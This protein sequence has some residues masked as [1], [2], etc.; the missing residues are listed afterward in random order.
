M[1]IRFI[2]KIKKIRFSDQFHFECRSQKNSCSKE[3][4]FFQ[5]YSP[6]ASYIELRSVIFALQVI[7]PF[8]QLGANIISLL[9]TAKISLCREA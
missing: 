7:L 4:E 3:Q 2:I 6:L 9:P 1:N 5:L 8:G